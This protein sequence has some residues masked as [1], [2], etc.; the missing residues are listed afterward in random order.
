MSIIKL[1]DLSVCSNICIY[2]CTNTIIIKSLKGCIYY[3][4]PN[5]YVDQSCTKIYSEMIHGLFS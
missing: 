3:L 1:N 4:R 5:I 2:L